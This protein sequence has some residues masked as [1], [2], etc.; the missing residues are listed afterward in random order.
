MLDRFNFH[1]TCCIVQILFCAV[2]LQDLHI[3]LCQA[4]LLQPYFLL[5]VGR[6]KIIA[7]SGAQISLEILAFCSYVSGGAMTTGNRHM[8]SKWCSVYQTNRQM[9][10]VC[11]TGQDFLQRARGWL[12]FLSFRSSLSQRGYSE[13]TDHME[14]LSPSAD[15]ILVCLSQHC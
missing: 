7:C 3:I 1:L 4:D 14:K 13:K 9:S 10:P 2:S 11:L 8:A 6:K 5:S 12:K 15:V